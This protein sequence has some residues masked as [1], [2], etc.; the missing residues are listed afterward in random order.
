MVIHDSPLARPSADWISRYAAGLLSSTP[1]L[2]PLDAVRR[3]MDAY[4]GAVGERRNK[5]AE[6]FA[7]PRGVH[8]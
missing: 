7:H 5:P 3:A 4:P 6:S 1:G 2:Q 8:R